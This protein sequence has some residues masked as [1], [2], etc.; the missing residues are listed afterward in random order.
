MATEPD[1]AEYILDKLG[2]RQIFT[3]RRMFGN[4]ALYANGLTVALICNDQLYVKILPE[5][6]KLEEV[7]EKDT[8]F[9]KAKLH[10]LVEESQLGEIADLPDILLDIA[11]ALQVGKKLKKV[12]K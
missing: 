3:V 11:E 5:S 7:C 4:Y 8:P 6:N 2:D 1:T 10:Y 12:V 9:P